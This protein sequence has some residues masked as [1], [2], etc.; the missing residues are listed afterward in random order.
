[1]SWSRPLLGCSLSLCIGV[2]RYLGPKGKEQLFMIYFFGLIFFLF[3][4]YLYEIKPSSEKGTVYF[5][6]EALFL[7]LFMGLRFHVGGDSIRYESYF[8]H[9][10]N[11]E[12]LLKY[13]LRE[14]YFQPLW[15]LLVGSCKSV[16]DNYY[17]FQFVHSLILNGSIV[18]FAIKYCKHRFTFLALY[19]VIVY[20]TFSAETMRE[21]LAVVA[22]LY[23]VYFLIQRKWLV[24]YA[25]LLI[26]YGF[27]ASA[28][29]LVILPL[30]YTRLANMRRILPIIGTIAVVLVFSF[31]LVRFDI[32]SMISSDNQMISEKIEGALDSNGLNIFGIAVKIFYQLPAII[33]FWYLD[34]SRQLNEPNNFCLLFY[35]ILNLVA[36]I[37][38]PLDR[39][40][41]Y[42]VVLYLLVF[43]DLVHDVNL[44]TWYRAYINISLV[45]LILWQVSYYRGR[46][47][48]SKSSNDF[49]YYQRYTPYYSIL[50]PG[51]DTER[52]REISLEFITR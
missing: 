16:Y 42:G 19:Y 51:Y 12:E 45:I 1:M 40:E 24:Y 39:M 25:F 4:I 29:P 44:K 7:I 35:L 22:F 31:L 13:G 48:G 5:I 37:Y 9:D 23:G 2:W 47:H 34:R 28:L 30:V 6:A 32:G 15:Q 27:H 38:V 8:L 50:A 36:I 10:Y 33:A 14:N 11:L 43:A 20:V 26:A 21:S 52:E 18:Y 49:R 41:D 46:V 3:P 17:F